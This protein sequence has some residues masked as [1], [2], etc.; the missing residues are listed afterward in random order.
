MYC[1]FL[2][3]AP[4]FREKC[5]DILSTFVYTFIWEIVRMLM[6]SGGQGRQDPMNRTA[7]CGIPNKPDGKQGG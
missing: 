4:R 3:F 7:F 5:F 2:K 1:F 6:P